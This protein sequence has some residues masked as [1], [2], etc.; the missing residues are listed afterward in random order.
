[1]SAY[2]F[3]TR[4]R[5]IAPP[6]IMPAL[7]MAALIM[8]VLIMTVLIMT[9]CM[10]GSPLAAHPFDATY[11][12]SRAAI[13]A[14]DL[15]LHVL[16]VVEVPTSMILEEFLTLYGDPTQL[17]EE[18]NEIF[19]QR[20]FE[21]LAKDLHLRINKKRASGSWR[22][23]DSEANGRGTETFFVYL[24]EFVHEDPAAIAAQASLDVRL[25]MEVFSRDLIYLSASA[26]G[27]GPWRVS[28]NSAQAILQSSDD[29]FFDPETGRW[30][31]DPR[32]RRL[33]IQFD[34]SESS[35]PEAGSADPATRPSP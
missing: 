25:E 31:I 5:A 12:S 8:A 10:I 7:A 21:K 35:D 26:E 15:G 29:E 17:D 19:R 27:Q 14:D 4:S 13:K 33:S 6:P 22:P 16:V 9:G 28:K 20:Q 1:M 3:P 2:P 23:V 34:R 30:S 24:L 32:L 18:A 11:Y